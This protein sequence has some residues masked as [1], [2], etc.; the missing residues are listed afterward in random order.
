MSK[1]QLAFLISICSVYSAFAMKTPLED[2][3][4]EKESY[5][6]IMEKEDPNLKTLAANMLAG[7]FVTEKHHKEHRKF[8]TD[9]RRSSQKEADGKKSDSRAEGKQVKKPE[10]HADSEATKTKDKCRCCIL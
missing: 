9:Q 3:A 5:S 7:A 6:D 8:Q 4:S 10:E 1:V 2:S